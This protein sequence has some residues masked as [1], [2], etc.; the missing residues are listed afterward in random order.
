MSEAREPVRVA[1]VG[2]A[3]KMGR[4]AVKALGTDDRF[5]VVAAVNRS[6]VGENCRDVAGMEA[7][8]LTIEGKLGAALD[9]SK[10][11]VLLELTHGG[12]APEYG[13]SALKRGI[14]VVIGSSGIGPD[15]LSA[16][17]D[18]AVEFS[19]PCLLVPNFAVGAVLM[20]RLVETVA[21]WMPDAE[22]VEM[23]HAGKLD[24]PSG[25]SA[26]TAELIA[27][28]RTRKP[29]RNA[30]AV[31]KVPGAR[32][33]TVHEVKVHSVRLPG[34]VAHQ[35]VMFGGEGEVLTVRHD[36]LDRR[37]FMPGVKLAVAGVRGLS[38]FVTG[39]DKVMFPQVAN[40]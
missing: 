23:H 14:A 4:E 13:T 2:A 11:D 26:H 21:P 20:M 38:G 16:L 30:M 3:G 36:S 19:R 31:E 37:S 8:D 40:D 6:R 29:G 10:P 34:L 7:P 25:T 15:G 22:I 35:M 9:A 1:I 12:S 39:L 33:A 24:A 5:E 32:G 27:E 28:A 18:A 17:R